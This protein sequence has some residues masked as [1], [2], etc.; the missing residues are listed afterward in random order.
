M[1]TRPCTRAG[2]QSHRGAQGADRQAADECH[3]RPPPG[4]GIEKDERS[5]SGHTLPSRDSLRAAV[6]AAGAVPYRHRWRRWSRNGSTAPSGRS[7]SRPE[8]LRVLGCDTDAPDACG[9]FLFSL[10]TPLPHLL[11][12]HVPARRARA[13]WRGTVVNT[14]KGCGIARVDTVTFMR[15]TTMH[16]VDHWYRSGWWRR[17][18]LP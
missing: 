17:H 7:G 12:H 1:G 9:R 10:R 5:A 3:A 2:R 11:R 16:V 6:S 8:F 15:A 4:P 13:V 14:A 18:R